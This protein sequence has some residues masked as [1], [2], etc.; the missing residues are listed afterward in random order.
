MSINDDSW[1]ALHAP[2][3]ATNRVVFSAVESPNATNYDLSA[4]ATE[5]P[6]KIPLLAQHADSFERVVRRNGKPS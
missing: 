6:C 5:V 1:S 2:Y 3:F 4:D